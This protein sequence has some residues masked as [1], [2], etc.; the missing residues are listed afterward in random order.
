MSAEQA[1]LLQS[2]SEARK[3]LCVCNSTQMSSSLLKGRLGPRNR[4][5]AFCHTQTPQDG[6]RTQDFSARPF[7]F[8]L[9]VPLPRMPLPL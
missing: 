4:T 8:G 3:A 2:P 5:H 9:D 1:S 6:L 7:D